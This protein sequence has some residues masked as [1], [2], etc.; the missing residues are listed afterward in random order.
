MTTTKRKNKYEYLHVVQGNY[1]GTGWEDIDCSENRRESQANLRAYRLNAHG[2]QYR[3]IQ[4][5]ELVRPGLEEQIHIAIA[6]HQGLVTDV[7]ASRSEIEVKP[8]D[9]PDEHWD[10]GIKVFTV[11]LDKVE[12]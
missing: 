5:R 6:M 4:R 9:E 10:N 1:E 12:S 11:H 3:L 7:S 8:K 2:Y